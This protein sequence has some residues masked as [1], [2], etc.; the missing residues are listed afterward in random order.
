MNSVLRIIIAQNGWVF[1][2][3]CCR[4]EDDIVIRK[5]FN[6]RRWGTQ[7]GLGQLALE[8]RQPDT[9]LDDYGVVHVPVVGVVSAVRCK[10]AAWPEE[11]PEAVDE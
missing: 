6:I 4:E 11:Y 7:S 2:G 8:G 5:C 3:M 1:M 9:V 10:A